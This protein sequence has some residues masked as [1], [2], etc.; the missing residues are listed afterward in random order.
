MKLAV[1][2]QEKSKVQ[3]FLESFGFNYKTQDYTFYLEDGAKII[4]TVSVKG[5]IIQY[6]AIDPNY[7]GENIAASIL[8]KLLNFLFKKNIHNPFVYT[9]PNNLEI[10]QALGFK[11]II[12]TKTISLLEFGRVRICDVLNKLKKEYNIEDEDLGCTVINGNP[13]TF[14]H[15]Y[16]IQ[17]ASSLHQKFLVFV[18]EEDLS[19]FSFSERYHLAREGTKEFSNVLVLPS[20]NYLISSLTFPTYFLK[21]DVDEVFEQAKLDAE[22]FNAY[23]IPILGIKRRYLGAETDK[24]T[25]KYNQALK[26]VLAEKVVIYERLKAGSEVISASIV[27]ELF[28]KKD[29]KALEDLVPKTT[30]E[31]LKEL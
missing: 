18:L 3:A 17:K 4:G 1:L 19:F 8:S 7:Q 23:F 21:A 27:R 5:N 6:F 25:S 13:F 12:S 30:L 11:E 2:N 28:A 16:L 9:K 24:V 31:F 14:G 26:D 20:T 10:F 22:L 29:F 15:Q